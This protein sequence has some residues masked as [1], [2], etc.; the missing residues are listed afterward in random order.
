MERRNGWGLI[1]TGRIA[2]ERI[3]PAITAF[4]ANDLVGV[5]SRDAARAAHFAAKFGARHAY[6]RYEDLLRDPAVTVVA[7][8]TPN[9]LH[10]EQAIAAA[11]AGKHVFCDKPLATDVADAKR[12]VAECE[13]AGVR[14]GVNF[15]NRFMPCFMDC[16]RII[17]SGE[18]GAV[19]LVSIEASPGDRVHERH[20]TWRLDPAMAGLGTTMS[21]GVHIYDI[22]R[23]MLGS[24]VETVAALFDT[25]RG[26][27]EHVNL[28]TFRF[29]N[30]AMAQAS[31]HETA[32]YPHNDLVIYGTRGRI[33]G[34]GVT[35]SRASGELEV[36]VGDGE[37]RR[38]RYPVINAHAACVADF[39]AALLENRPPAADGIDGL[40]S[41]QLTDAMA[42]SAWDGAHVQIADP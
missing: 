29:R 7:I 19:R 24:E 32:P 26:V 8:H 23:Y 39:S 28:S 12:I 22:L 31:I 17:E 3:L 42:R 18:I 27:M 13:Q 34:R 4:A 36:L 2:D 40:R 35:R 30:G 38:M 10:A 11:R 25:P 41:V 5:V 15:H 9:A 20:G 6:T 33:T 21:I 16:R 14:L 37:P 1:G